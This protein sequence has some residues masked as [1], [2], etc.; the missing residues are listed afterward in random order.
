MCTVSSIIVILEH[1]VII[2]PCPDVWQNLSFRC[3]ASLGPVPSPFDCY[4]VCRGLKT[5]PVRMRQHEKNALDIACFLEGHP[6]VKKVLYPGGFS[7]IISFY[8]TGGKKEAKTFVNNLRIF[9]SAASLGCV[10]SLVEI[11][12][13]ISHNGIE[14]EYRLKNGITDN[15]IRL[16][17]GLEYTEDLLNDLQQALDKSDTG[18]YPASLEKSYVEDVGICDQERQ[19]GRKMEV[20]Y[21]FRQEKMKPRWAS[22]ACRSTGIEKVRQGSS[23]QEDVSVKNPLGYGV[24]SHTL[25]EQGGVSGG[26]PEF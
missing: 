5:L 22:M 7:G 10:A 20:S 11:P 25:E 14:E 15:L 23:I 24:H 17:V 16:S 18:Q 9:N 1:I 2:K 3:D 8:I 6:M 12:A 21:F 4:L 26:E 19:F 13:D